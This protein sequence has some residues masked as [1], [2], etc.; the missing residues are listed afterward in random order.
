MSLVPARWRADVALCP[1]PG[2]DELL[3]EDGCNRLH[4]V[5]LQ[6][7]SLDRGQLSVS[8][9]RVR[10]PAISNKFFTGPLRR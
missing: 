9:E 1:P 10:Q 3:R 2:D 4:A 6:G 5:L 8:A 7:M